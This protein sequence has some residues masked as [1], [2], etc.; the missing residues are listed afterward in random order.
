MDF[1]SNTQ[2]AYNNDYPVELQKGRS[3]PIRVQIERERT[4]HE[5]EIKRLNQMMELIEANPAIEQFIN[6]QRGYTE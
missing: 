2:G 6:L 5:Q 4:V 3:I 1:L